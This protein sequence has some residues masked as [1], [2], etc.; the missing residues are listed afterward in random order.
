MGLFGI[1]ARPDSA[2][3]LASVQDAP[4]AL[5]FMNGPDL[6]GQA[7]GGQAYDDPR[8]PMRAPQKFNPWSRENVGQFGDFLLAQAGNPAGL[9]A[10]RQR[11]DRLQQQ[12]AFERGEQQYQRRRGDQQTDYLARL[13]AQRENPA[14]TDFERLMIAS[15]IDP[16]SEEG[17][18]LYQQRLGREVSQPESGLERQIDYL[19]TL[20]QNLTD[21]QA[22][23]IAK[24]GVGGYQYSPEAQAGRIATAGAVANAQGAARAAHRAPQTSSATGGSGYEYRVVNGK[25]QRR[26]VQ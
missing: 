24:R 9:L 3:R 25:L 2:R 20:N 15:G 11:E 10:M 18:R 8:G 1:A 13:R 14:P 21:E 23:E 7:T 4:D 6:T 5:S 12:T 16:R 17:Q 19:R 26:K 22:F